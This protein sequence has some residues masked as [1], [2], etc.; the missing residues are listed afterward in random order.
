MK[1]RL[2][3]LQ[4]EL[5]IGDFDAI[6]TGVGEVFQKWPDTIPF[7]V[8]CARA[9]I[10]YLEA[11]LRRPGSVSYELVFEEGSKAKEETASVPL[12]S[13]AVARFRPLKMREGWKEDGRMIQLLDPA[14]ALLID[15]CGDKLITVY[16]KADVADFREVLSRLPRHRTKMAK[17]QK[18]ECAGRCGARAAAD[19]SQD[20][21]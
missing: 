1:R 21:Q 15:I 12:F 16:S 6:Q 2:T 7:L 19:Q 10:E 20:R 5:E 8:G 3:T 4:D 14:A 17:T 18:L 11:R 9:Q 13:A